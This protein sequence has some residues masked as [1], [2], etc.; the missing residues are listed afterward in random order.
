MPDPTDSPKHRSTRVASCRD[1]PPTPSQPTTPHVRLFDASTP[2]GNR[3]RFFNTA[4]RR[5]FTRDDTTATGHTHHERRHRHNGVPQ[6]HSRLHPPIGLARCQPRIASGSNSG[7]IDLKKKTRWNH[8]VQ[9]TPARVNPE[10]TQTPPSRSTTHA[11][12]MGH[13]LMTEH[14]GRRPSAHPTPSRSITRATHPADSV[15]VLI[16]RPGHG[17]MGWP[18]DRTGMPSHRTVPCLTPATYGCL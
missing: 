17:Q 6:L 5:P 8:T 4:G 18:R 10:E 12:P 9:P 13:V 7:V 1:V 3:V 11:T 15:A 2:L 14:M 16:T